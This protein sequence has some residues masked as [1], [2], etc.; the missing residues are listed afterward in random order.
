MPQTSS[1]TPSHP[2]HQHTMLDFW[3]VVGIS[4][5]KSLLQ[6]TFY[7]RMRMKG[8][9]PWCADTREPWTL[10]IDVTRVEEPWIYRCHHLGPSNQSRHSPFSCLFFFYLA[11]AWREQRGIFCSVWKERAVLFVLHGVCCRRRYC[12]QFL[13]FKVIN[14]YGKVEC[15]RFSKYVFVKFLF[16]KVVYE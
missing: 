2:P 6:S 4:I 14:E 16:F 13:F 11:L 1:T 10:R 7:A 15:A 9:P 12:V 8:N 5:G 3:K